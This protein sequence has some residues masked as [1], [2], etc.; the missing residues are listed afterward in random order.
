MF[1]SK[2]VFLSKGGA[3]GGYTVSRSVRFRSSASAYLSRTLGSNS[4]SNTTATFSVWVKRGALGTQQRIYSATN[5]GFTG[6]GFIIQFGSNDAIG[7]Y[8]NGSGT[9]Y[10]ATNA[11]FR[12]PSSWYHIFVAVNTVA[13][14]L[15]IYVN[16]VQQ[17]TTGTPLS[18]SAAFSWGS[19]NPFRI[20]ADTYSGASYLDSYLAEVYWID[21]QALTPSSFGATDATTGVWQPTKYSGTYGTNGFYLNFSSNGTAAALGT[22]FSGNSNTWTVNN[23]SVTS[24]VT[25]DS[26]TD[27]PT[28]TSATVANYPTLNPTA[29]YSAGNTITASNGNLTFNQATCTANTGM[30]SSFLAPTGAGLFYYEITQQTKTTVGGDQTQPFVLSVVKTANG[31]SPSNAFYYWA[32]GGSTGDPAGATLTGVNGTSIAN[33]DVIMVAIDLAAGKLYLGKN[34]TWLN[35]AVPASGTGACATN[36]L[37]YATISPAVGN[38][39]GNMTNFTCSLNFGQRPFTYT[40]PSGFVALNTYNLSAGS[41]TTSGSFTGNASADGPFIY[42][43]GVPTAMTINGNSVTFGTN[44]DHLA[45]G[46]KVRSAS[47][48]YNAAGSNTYSIT[49]TGDKFKYANAQ[50]NP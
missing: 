18:G 26:M 48:S 41:I 4:T 1:A 9:P 33:S 12:D 40:P 45:N 47:A 46:F 29:I 38:G 5:S 11:V 35:S 43:N 30:G 50:T 8:E 36:L 3:A 7:V 10:I 39:G 27:V 44:A 6:N 34:G 13:G 32:G 15:V 2:D 49:T 23:I 17:T 14:T 20:G 21:G 28:L 25:Y 22:D 37:N 24:G 42:L 19:G 16:G 31:T